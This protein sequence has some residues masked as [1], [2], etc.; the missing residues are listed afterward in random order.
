[1]AWTGEFGV[2]KSPRRCE[3]R[4]QNSPVQ[5]IC[6]GVPTRA[7]SVQRTFAAFARWCVGEMGAITRTKSAACGESSQQIA[8][9]GESPS[10]ERTLRLDTDSGQK[11]N[12]AEKQDPVITVISCFTE[13]YF[14]E[15]QKQ[16]PVI[17][18]FSLSRNPIF[19]EAQKQGPVIS[20]SSC[21]GILFFS[22]MSGHTT[23]F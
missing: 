16:D 17:S 8:A 19:L 7:N 9:L 5:A 4:T 10:C 22:F 18:C 3:F 23:L 1:M 12:Q 21:H 2:L 6:L 13:S 20:C 15:A 11:K 14:L